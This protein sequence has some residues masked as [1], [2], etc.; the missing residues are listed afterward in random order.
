LND[1][2]DEILFPIDRAGLIGVRR[3]SLLREHKNKNISVFASLAG[4]ALHA[5]NKEK[6][7][8]LTVNF[9]DRGA[10]YP[11][12]RHNGSRFLGSETTC[13]QS[14]AAKTTN[15]LDKPP[16]LDSVRSFHSRRDGHLSTF[17]S[18]GEGCH[19]NDRAECQN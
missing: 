5:D 2:R 4:R 16:P 3:S 6:L 13:W 7:V 10:I 14:V 17:V 18:C 11:C 19:G 15:H 9:F 1:F 8:F 12:Q